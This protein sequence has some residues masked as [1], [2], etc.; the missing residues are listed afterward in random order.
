MDERAILVSEMDEV[1]NGCVY[2]A[3]SSMKLFLE[4][5]NIANGVLLEHQNNITALST[6]FFKHAQKTPWIFQKCSLRG[7]YVVKQCFV[8]IR[9]DC[10]QL[11]QRELFLEMQRYCS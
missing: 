7:I 6:E 10:N 4:S 5:T 2:E 11:C 3:N 9:E 1:M 8:R